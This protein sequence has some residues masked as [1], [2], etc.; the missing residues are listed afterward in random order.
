MDTESASSAEVDASSLRMGVGHAD[1]PIWKDG[2]VLQQR[3]KGMTKKKVWKEVYLVLSTSAVKIYKTDA[4]EKI[5]F[6]LLL[7]APSMKAAVCP[8]LEHGVIISGEGGKGKQER[9]A[10]QTA[11]AGIAQAWIHAINHNAGLLR[12][13]QF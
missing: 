13:Q 5:H 10:L 7:T 2:P 1:D 3:A 8:K 9:V 4:R 6:E 12:Q 11:S